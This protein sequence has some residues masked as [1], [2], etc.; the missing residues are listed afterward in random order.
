HRFAVGIGVT[1]ASFAVFLLGIALLNL[2]TGIDW[3]ALR[4]AVGPGS[5]T[6]AFRIAH[7]ATLTFGL[8]GAALALSGFERYRFLAT[9]VAALAG[10]FAVFA[11]LGYLTGIEMLNASALLASPSLPTVVGLL[12]V[13]AGIILRIGAMPAL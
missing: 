9:V 13:D 6:A 11:L 12:C 4:S 2:D 3:L 1:V 10:A 8:T 5:E 7:T